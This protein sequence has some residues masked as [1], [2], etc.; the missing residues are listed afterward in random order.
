MNR[1]MTLLEEELERAEERLKIA[2]DKLEEATHTA[3]ESE[4]SDVGIISQVEKCKEK[5][6]SQRSKPQPLPNYSPLHHVN[7]GNAF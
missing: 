1:R 3:D 6:T 4:R 5:P 7:S 2:T